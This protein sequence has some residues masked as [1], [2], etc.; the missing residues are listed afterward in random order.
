MA[1]SDFGYAVVGTF[2]DLILDS[3]SYTASGTGLTITGGNSALYVDA[4]KTGYIVEGTGI[5]A[6]TTIASTGPFV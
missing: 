2:N 5:P 1:M 6:G 3:C 4:V